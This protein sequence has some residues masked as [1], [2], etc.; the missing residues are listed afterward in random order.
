M[1]IKS[2]L[3]ACVAIMTLTFSAALMPMAVSAAESAP[4]ITTA[5]NGVALATPICN[6]E[7]LATMGSL[8]GCPAAISVDFSGTCYNQAIHK[9]E[10]YKDGVLLT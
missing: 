9:V 4:C 6:Y 7:S 1:S 8:A 2:F 5:M 10:T 3:L